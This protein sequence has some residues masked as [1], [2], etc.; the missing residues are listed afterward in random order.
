MK[1]PKCGKELHHHYT[2][3]VNFYCDCGYNFK[4]HQFEMIVMDWQA[5]AEKAESQLATIKAET[6]DRVE[7]ALPSIFNN[8]H[9]DGYFLSN[10]AFEHIEAEVKKAISKIRGEEK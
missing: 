1:C 2:R 8:A 7:A 6:L 3:Q 4:E 10:S 9:K 5:R